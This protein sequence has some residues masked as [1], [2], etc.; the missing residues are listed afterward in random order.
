VTKDVADLIELAHDSGRACGGDEEGSLKD[1]GGGGDVAD[2]DWEAASCETA[3][4]TGGA[5]TGEGCST[6]GLSASF[7]GDVGSSNFVST[8]W[9]A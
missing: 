4:A 5:C 2:T 1:D 6:T 7:T 3:A 9:D 8:C